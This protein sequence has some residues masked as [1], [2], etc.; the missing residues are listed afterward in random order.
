MRRVIL[1]W[2][3]P[4]AFWVI[5][6]AHGAAQVCVGDCDGD[7][8]VGISELIRGVGVSLGNLPLSSC[9]ALD[10]NGDGSVSISELIRAVNNA[11]NGCE[12]CT[13]IGSPSP[14][15]TETPNGASPTPS[16]AVSTPTPDSEPS[17][18][19]DTTP[20]PS[21]PT[22]V[23]PTP[24]GGLALFGANGTDNTTV[25]VTFNGVVDQATGLDPGS[26]QIVQKERPEAG[27]PEV[28]DVLF[29]MTCDGGPEAGRACNTT[30]EDIV[31]AGANRCPEAACSVEDRS[32]VV[33]VTG[34][35]TML[36]YDLTVTGVRD[37][38]GSI[39]QVFGPFGDVRNRVSY[40]GE[41]VESFRHCPVATAA[42][43][44]AS[45]RC[46][47]VRC[48][49][50]DDCP[51]GDFC[52]ERLLDCDGDGLTDD[53]EA[54]GWDVTVFG[55]GGTIVS[56]ELVT[57]N[58][59][60][61]D[62]DSDGLTD[63]EERLSDLI[64]SI[65]DPR[66]RDTDGDGLDD[67]R[68]VVLLRTSPAHSDHDADGL[69]DGQEMAAG[70]S[71]RTAD[72]DGDS[73][74][75]A[76][77]FGTGDPRI[78]DLPE[79][80]IELGATRV[81]LNYEWRFTSEERSIGTISTTQSG[82]FSRGDSNESKRVSSSASEWEVKVAAEAS[83]N[84]TNPE[85]PSGFLDYFE[86]NAKVTAEAGIGIKGS[87]VGTREDS[88]TLAREY[89]RTRESGQELLNGET[90]TR[91]VTGATVATEVTF[92][93]TG[94]LDMRLQNV[95]VT[96]R[97]A[98]P[99]DPRE[100][101]TI[102]ELQPPDILQGPIELGTAVSTTKGPFE[103]STVGLS[104]LGAEFVDR[105][106]A[107]PRALVFDVGNVNVETPIPGT[108]PTQFTPF[109]AKEQEIIANTSQ[110]TVDFAGVGDRTAQ[111][112]F[113]SA[114]LGAVRAVRD[115]NGDGE[116]DPERIYFDES[117]LVRPSL[118]D[119]LAV[120]GLDV[121]I[122]ETDGTI[123]SI[124]GIASNLEERREW[125]LIVEDEPGAASETPIAS[126]EPDRRVD[127]I[128]MVPGRKVWVAYL[129]DEDGDGVPR[130]AEIFFGTSDDSVDS[131]GDGVD[132]IDEAFHAYQ[133]TFETLSQTNDSYSSRSNPQL[134]DTDADGLTDGEERQLLFTAADRIDS[135]GDLLDDTTE[136][137]TEGL[138][139]LDVDSDDDGTADGF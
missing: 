30:A 77:D 110:I 20:T 32:R 89:K 122:D 56:Q 12:P 57:S 63:D 60:K 21:S 84:T 106:M 90:E 125:I 9:S 98:D 34:P 99:N 50:N 91:V 33:L 4:L 45:G 67:F 102:G 68:E 26:Y 66:R 54:R 100:F 137:T 23:P 130:R 51:D 55:L 87:S 53:I 10:A 7:C 64:N 39:I 43:T 49:S 131:D 86:G 117:G 62:T 129:Q 136:V 6:P 46:N 37:T 5:L 126:F 78:A 138:D 31:D 65:S 132:D 35:Q 2:L 113:V 116:N 80:A 97:T 18:T 28:L 139:P 15:P 8:S 96:V 128:L 19:P 44:L 25:L 14:S 123:T 29:L 59:L 38:A 88:T 58:P 93:N 95:I 72:T 22:P 81:T 133:V 70:Y 52:V 42:M 47:A 27:G 75:D 71:P 105:L 36:V 40:T 118:R 114:N 111:R 101:I 3:I 135:D 107:N 48:Q 79:F 74:P 11:L 103:F 120:I 121:S 83:L 13:P 134:A 127:D 124:E 104:E 109:F 112:F 108:Q 41:P 73:I 94:S 92:V 82:T 16:A 119:A 85:D 1:S 24:N 61:V 115:T 69:S 76:E 17:A